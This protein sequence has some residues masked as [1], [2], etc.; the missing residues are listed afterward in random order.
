MPA[1]VPTEPL[2]AR[3]TREILAL[4]SWTRSRGQ[5]AGLALAYALGWLLLATISHRFWFLPA[6]LRLG[7]LWILPTRYWG[8]LLVGEWAGQAVFAF[9]HGWAF[10][11]RFV[12]T[13]LVPWLVYAGL[14]RLVRGPEAQSLVDDPQRML[15]LLSAGVLAAACVSPLLQWFL[16]PPDQHQG[17]LGAFGFLYGDFLGQLVLAPLIMLMARAD[18]RA[19]L[20]LGLARDVAMQLLF[21]LL[22]FWLIRARQDLE[23]YIL[24]LAFAPMFFVAFRRGWEGAAVS[25]A[26]AGL[27]VQALVEFGMLPVDTRV[28]QL[29]LAVMGGG[30]LVLGAASSALRHSHERLASRHRDLA[31]MNRSLN[32]SASELRAVSQRLVRMEE[33]GQ[34]ELAVELDY[35]LG[36][37]I[38]ALSTR[39]SLAFRD[40]REEQTLRLLES[41]RE[42][43]REMHESL[44]R[45]L[46]QLRPQALDTHGLREALD[47]GPLRDTLE[48]AGIAYETA[49]YG[50][51]EAMNDDAQTMVYRICQAAVRD[52]A[53]SSS[54][55]RVL[56]RVD[57]VPAT[58]E[59]IEVRMQ[60]D[61]EATQFL[62]FPI[63]PHPLEAI[64]DRVSSQHG[65]YWI[66]PLA[67]GVRHRIRFEDFEKNGK[68]GKNGVR[69][70]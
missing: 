42:Q 10:D 15:L 62:E 44:R 69:A 20:D 67:P 14:V 45:V 56:V 50:R 23:P 19:R 8:W 4:G 27:L 52:A 13:G 49:F 22:V 32:A 26:I 6:G 9:S 5:R 54:S 70:R 37:S 31:Q 61:I 65:A 30:G 34:R 17:I 33:Q 39:I 68:N 1:P 40:V 29:S 51:I 46:R 59:R 24:L 66:E 7:A 2:L 48:D 64:T 3:S 57:V 38:H 55:R 35:E 16:L 28:L 11:A 18:L 21:S 53:R 58:D 36:R 47:F 60:L 12:G 25:V 43:V 63:E 41:M